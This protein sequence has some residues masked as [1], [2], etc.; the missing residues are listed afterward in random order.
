[1]RY[2]IELQFPLRILRSTVCKI[3]FENNKEII[4]NHAVSLV[5]TLFNVFKVLGD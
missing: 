5:L 1:M 2:P 4:L 3:S